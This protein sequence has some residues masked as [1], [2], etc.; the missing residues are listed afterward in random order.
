MCL[1]YSGYVDSDG[2]VNYSFKTKE[3][4]VVN[5]KCNEDW[6][7]KP[8]PVIVLMELSYSKQNIRYLNNFEVYCVVEKLLDKTE[9]QQW[10]KLNMSEW[11]DSFKMEQYKELQEQT[12]IV[13]YWCKA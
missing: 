2:V 4:G 8:N 5:F 3:F 13:N 7:R 11:L 1:S 6:L 10:V 9:D 12:E